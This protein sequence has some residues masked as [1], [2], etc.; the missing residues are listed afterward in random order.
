MTGRAWY[1][2]RRLGEALLSA[3]SRFCNAAFLGGSTSESV[4]AR[5]YREPWPRAVAVI[6]AALWIFE[7]D[8][9]RKAWDVEL[10]D[11]RKTLER[12]EVI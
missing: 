1:I 3:V 2:I 4:S 9:C 10:S 12:N 7:R 8:H 5:S 11:A 6:N